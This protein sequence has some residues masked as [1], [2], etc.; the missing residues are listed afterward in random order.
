[1]QC[2]YY[3]PF[4]VTTRP[5]DCFMGPFEHCG[6][7]WVWQVHLLSTHCSRPGAA[8]TLEM[9]SQPPIL[10]AM[11]DD[12][13]WMTVVCTNYCECY[14]LLRHLC[15]PCHQFTG[16]TGLRRVFFFTCGWST[17]LRLPKPHESSEGWDWRSIQCV[18][19]TGSFSP[20][21]K[22]LQQRG[23][24]NY[25][26]VTQP[27]DFTRHHNPIHNSTVPMIDA[28][29]KKHMK[30]HNTE[31]T[32]NDWKEALPFIGATHHSTKIDCLFLVWPKPL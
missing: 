23:P 25:A 26:L 18:V 16:P 4:S 21:F 32:M 19:L 7:N 20:S 6:R 8:A 9:Q 29:E 31:I 28:R 15:S 5:F 24:G 14:P 13:W 2:P 11:K 1:M 22:T 3:D 27:R 12:V 30:T 10:C 17:T